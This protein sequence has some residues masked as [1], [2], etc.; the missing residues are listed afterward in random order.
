MVNPVKTRQGWVTL[1][2]LG[3]ALL[4][5]VA[6]YA[7]SKNNGPPNYTPEE[8]QK[9][10]KKAAKDYT[11]QLKKQQKRTSKEQKKQ[12]KEWKKEHPTT[13]TVSY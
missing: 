10:S 4:V 3:L 9:S 5:P 8:A 2:L 11:K 1:I 7:G 13:S 12:L 6:S